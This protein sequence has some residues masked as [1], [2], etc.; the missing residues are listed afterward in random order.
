MRIESDPVINSP[1]YVFPSGTASVSPGL[2]SS[3]SV[4]TCTT[5]SGNPSPFTS[6]SDAMGIPFP[7]S[8]IG[9]FAKVTVRG[10]TVVASNISVLVTGTT[11]LLPR[12]M[13]LG[14]LFGAPQ[15]A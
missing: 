8:L 10:S 5:R 7:L 3:A 4:L 2:S 6:F 14:K 9:A 1:Q 15:P 11:P 13:L 12:L